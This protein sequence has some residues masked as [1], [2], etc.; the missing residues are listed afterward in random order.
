MSVGSLFNV[1]GPSAG[2]P[3]EG[4]KGL[5]TS[6][7]ARL[8]KEF[9]ANELPQM[10]KRSVFRVAVGVLREPMILLLLVSA[11]IYGV[12]GDVT[13]ALLLIGSAAVVIAINIIQDVRSE[14]A[15]DAL[16]N[17]TS[18]HAI[19]IRDG[20]SVRI[21]AK[22][23]VPGD[24]LTIKEGDR[25]TADAELLEGRN[26]LLDESLI[27]GE[28][29]AVEKLIGDRVEVVVQGEPN[30]EV[31]LYSGSL[32]VRGIGK[33]RVTATGAHSEVGK[34]GAALATSEEEA[35]P[36]FVQIRKFV[37]VAATISILFCTVTVVLFRITRGGWIE[38]LLAGVSLAMSLLPEEFPVILAIFLALGAR[39][40]AGRGILI[41][42]LSAVEALGTV[43]V[44]CV[45]KTGTLTRNEMTLVEIRPYSSLTSETSASAASA[46][47]ASATA[48]TYSLE[49]SQ[50]LSDFGVAP[51]S[52]ASLRL[53]GI[54]ALA[55]QRESYD[56]M[57]IATHAADTH[58]RTKVATD[59]NSKMIER[60]AEFL[61]ADQLELVQE[62]SLT[63]EAP[64]FTNVWKTA[65]GYQVAIKGSP[66]AVIR[67]CELPERQAR[68]ILAALDDLAKRGLRVLGVAYGSSQSLL[69]NAASYKPQFLGLA[70]YRDPLREGIRKSVEECYEA[71]IRT[72]MLTGDHPLTARTIASE[73]GIRNAELVLT[74][75]EMES[76]SAQE[77]QEKLKAVNVFARISPSQ[78]LELVKLLKASGAIVAMTGDGVNDAPALKTA[79]IG[80]AMGGR[81]TDVAR[82]AASVILTQDDFPTLV[83]SVRLGRRTY[84]NIKKAMYY[85][86]AMHFPVAGLAILPLLT[87]L[88]LIFYPIHIVL[89][90]LLLDPISSLVF[91]SEPEESNIM[92]RL[93]RDPRAPIFARRNLIIA[94]LQG[95]F[96]FVACAAVYLYSY[97]RTHSE[98]ESRT[99]TFATLVLANLAL[100]VVNR[101]W[102][103]VFLASLRVRNR[104][105]W[106]CLAF[107]VVVLIVITEVP[108]IARLFHFGPFHLH[109]WLICGAAAAASVTWFELL[110]LFSKK[111]ADGLI[112]CL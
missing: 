84:D 83:L 43:T 87:G 22:D 95:V 105:L 11:G 64:I 82:E 28:S 1:P 103:T 9:G 39:R 4:G 46:S 73:A 47:A 61:R 63:P 77:L 74:G 40:L 100:A 72:I 76:V 102:S 55:S 106:W 32:V 111:K 93:P 42:R 88:P 48:A 38:A 89:I 107:G 27:T 18:P 30:P 26:I 91:E 99:L 101:S 37:R 20:I 29:N 85:V 16:K 78:K 3:I 10:Q 65:S 33:A 5:S 12:L 45:D 59:S 6:E 51:L 68:E 66:E 44:L 23:V 34:I 79:H 2:L 56:P 58:Y 25:I 49:P 90:E 81:G 104:A 36:L 19:V 17:L 13:E 96:V 98:F 92:Q 80:V 112:F 7:A 75:R 41:R 97:G 35:T 24:I 109:D 15:L 50:T 70:A 54:A 69:G 110:K 71:G 57:D 14:R 62:I 60:S 52:P 108:V 86:I 31:T 21:P 94:S 8:L 67:A 53:L